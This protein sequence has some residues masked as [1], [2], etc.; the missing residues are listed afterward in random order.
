[1]GQAVFP[2][3][4]QNLHPTL[5]ISQLY[6]SFQ[7]LQVFSSEKKLPPEGIIRCHLAADNKTK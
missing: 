1:M 6:R 2:H 7:K 4:E 3:P 5:K